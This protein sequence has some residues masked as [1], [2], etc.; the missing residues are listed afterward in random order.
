MRG[1]VTSRHLPQVYRHFPL[2]VALKA[3]WGV[4]RAFC[5]GRPVTFL[6]LI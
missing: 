6:S 5:G 3:T 4:L 1:V 2:K